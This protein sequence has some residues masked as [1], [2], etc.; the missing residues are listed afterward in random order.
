MLPSKLKVIS[1]V[2]AGVLT[3][4]ITCMMSRPTFADTD[5]GM[6]FGYEPDP[7]VETASPTDVAIDG[8]GY[9]ILRPPGSHE[10]EFYTRRGNFDIDTDGYLVNSGGHIV[11]GWYLAIHPITGEVCDIGSITDIWLPPSLYNEMLDIIEA[12]NFSTVQIDESGIITGRDSSGQTHPLFRIAVAK[13]QDPYGLEHK[14]NFLF[15]QTTVSGEAITSRP[16]EN[17]MGALVAYRLE[18]INPDKSFELDIQVDGDGYFLLHPPA[19]GDAIYFTPSHAFRFDKEGYLFITPGYVARGWKVEQDDIS[20]EI[21]LVGSI[22]DIQMP[23]FTIPPEVTENITVIVNLDAGSTNNSLGNNALSHVWDG[24]TSHDFPISESAYEH[25]VTAKAYDR[26]GSTHDIMFFFDR[27]EF[28]NRF[29]FIVTCNPSE[30]R[31]TFFNGSTSAAGLGMLGRGVLIFDTNDN[32]EKIEFESYIGPPGNIDD[33]SDPNGWMEKTLL[34]GGQPPVVAP[35]FIG[36]IKGVSTVLS[37]AIDF[38]LAFDGSGWVSSTPTSTHANV[39]SA[40]IFQS[41]DGHGAGDLVQSNVDKN[42]LI[43]NAYSQGVILPVF[44]MALAIFNDAKGLKEI[45][46]GSKIFKATSQSGEPI[47]SVPGENGLGTL[48]FEITP[49]DPQ[50]GGSG[51]SSCF[52]NTLF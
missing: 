23:S 42:G 31:R 22:T 52:L 45:S 12:L 33:L 46:S 13:F 20:G 8:I 38:G 36:G 30:D 48:S 34:S 39:P 5:S 14:G 40:T 43:T 10:E 41:A 28:N 4:A 50:T 21:E 6:L 1:I 15:E 44:Q 29:E 2:L 27:G 26:L 18:E 51:S 47:T 25:K 7:F 9:F 49:D 24:D 32:L 37:I 16:N 35:D 17:G 11:R 19:D 3:I